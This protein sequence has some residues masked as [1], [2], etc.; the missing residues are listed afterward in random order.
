MTRHKLDNDD[1]SLS[2]SLGAMTG[3]DG[4]SS[5]PPTGESA[6][7]Y[8]WLEKSLGLTGNSPSLFMRLWAEIVD[9]MR[10]RNS[11]QQTFLYGVDWPSDYWIAKGAKTADV[12][13]NFAASWSPPD[14]LTAWPSLDVGRLMESGLPG[15]AT[16]TVY[17][18][19]SGVAATGEVGIRDS[20]E[21]ALQFIAMESRIERHGDTIM[22][23]GEHVRAWLQCAV[24]D[25]LK[26]IFLS[27]EADDELLKSA[28]GIRL[29]APLSVSLPEMWLPANQFGEK[30]LDVL[31]NLRMADG[32]LQVPDVG[33]IRTG[34]GEGWRQSWDWLS[35]DVS[36]SVMRDA[37]R[38]AARIMRCTPVVQGGLFTGVAC[39]TKFILK[40]ARLR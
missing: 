8:A 1:K 18:P 38:M 23:H 20:A 15:T 9:R 25:F 24:G 29:S 40:A 28:T 21:A 11:V 17:S 39:F 33:D 34:Q 2:T 32:Q 35:S 10:A 13:R 22:V 7:T 5:P 6:T 36:F 26:A 31:Y 27:P 30:T 14:G 4:I 19:P 37:V 3:S 12:I 16:H